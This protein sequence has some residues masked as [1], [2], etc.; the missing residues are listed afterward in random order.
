MG[1]IELNPGT[2]EYEEFFKDVPRNKIARF[3]CE[4]EHQEM[5]SEEWDQIAQQ[6]KIVKE[7]LRTLEAMEI[8]LKE[9]LI[10][11]AGARSSTGG[12]IQLT[13]IARKGAIDYGRIPELRG[14]DLEPY[15]KEGSEYWKISL[16]E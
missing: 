5:E 1:L 12:G 11:L 10:R 9:K 13:Q 14:V 6:Y 4:I 2:P 15:R 8:D 3:P 16:S 7:N